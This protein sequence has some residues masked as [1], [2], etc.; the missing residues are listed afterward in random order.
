M[1][2]L[3]LKSTIIP[4]ALV[5]AANAN[6][7]LG[8]VTMGLS[9]PYTF[10]ETGF[11]ASLTGTGKIISGNDLIGMYGFSV[12]AQTVT[13]ALSTSL[14]T[15]CLSPL[16][17]LA[18]DNTQHVY[19][20]VAN[21]DST[22]RKDS[23]PSLQ[24]A[25]PVSSPNAGILNAQFLYN[26]L[27][28]EITSANGLANGQVGGL[29]VQGAAMALAMYTALYNSTGYGVIGNGGPLTISPLSGDTST[30]YNTDLALLAANKSAIMNSHPAGS[31]LIP[32][33]VSSGF[34]N[35][36]NGPDGQEMILMTT[37]LS[38]GA[39]AVPEAST[40]ISGLLMLLPFG[41]GILRII[42]TKAV[43]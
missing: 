11:T 29:N 1:R 14:W 43:K 9:D 3:T 35:P 28:G 19:T 16:G 2:Y 23:Y 37:P 31:V 18:N 30:D 41:A 4:A 10:D 15:V 26:S 25:T 5:A 24:W 13:P 27:S 6:A 22:A 36:A 39:T 7:T 34:I 32:N 42:R 38:Q 8:T 21:T 20:Q 17:L 40:V 12:S 33:D